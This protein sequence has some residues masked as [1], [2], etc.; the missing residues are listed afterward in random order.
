MTN[1]RG[2][3][4]LETWAN[5]LQRR[6]NIVGT[7]QSE[8]IQ[9]DQKTYDEDYTLACPMDAML[10]SLRAK[11][12]RIHWW[13]RGTTITLNVLTMDVSQ[14][15]RGAEAIFKCRRDR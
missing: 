13:Q 14:T 10:V 6:A 1:S 15:G 5:L 12:L 7:R 11:D 4:P 9:N 2:G 3:Q 8:Q